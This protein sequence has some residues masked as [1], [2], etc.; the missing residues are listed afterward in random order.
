MIIYDDDVQQTGVSFL[1]QMTK[2][3]KEMV[4]VSD[5][6]IRTCQLLPRW[7]PHASDHMHNLTLNDSHP[8]NQYGI[9]CGST[10]EFFIRPLN[11]CIGDF[12]CL[13]C[14]TD[15]LAFSG[16]FPVLPNDISGLADTINCYEIKSYDEFPGFV[17]LRPSGEMK[18]N[19]KSK[20]Y[21]FK[22]NIHQSENLYAFINISKNSYLQVLENKWRS[23]KKVSYL[24]CVDCGPALKFPADKSTT[25]FERDKVNCIFCPQ[26]PKEARLWPIRVRTFGWPTMNTI[27]EVVQNGCH[28]VYVQHR[29][30]RNHK[31]QWRFSFSL[32]EVILLQSWTK[33]QQIV[34]HLLRFFA[35][36]ELF[37]KDCPKEDEVLC[38]YHL[39][40]LMLWTCEE[41]SPE[42][43]NSFPV[44]AI[45]SEMLAI[46]SEWLKRRFCPNY[47]I[48]E[49]NLFHQPSRS[50]VLHQTQRRLNDFSISD[51]LSHWFVENYILPITRTQL[52]FLNKGNV[53]THFMGYLLPLLEYRKAAVSD[54]LNDML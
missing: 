38:T 16:D 32:A 35:K 28:I 8:P 21:T 24:K 1:F 36:R 44:I 3:N 42:W 46:L 34:Y 17:R 30:S 6:I 49:A 54:S 52:K 22:R 9:V 33:T 31:Q 40:T 7:R 13:V 50:A 37:Q 10:A 26:W 29:S 12:D 2:S 15:H 14:N 47:F 45:C 53:I 4:H 41:M 11:T 19:W 20:E 39:K 25:N 43:W 27:S 18:Y 48:P 51:I 5:F 23:K